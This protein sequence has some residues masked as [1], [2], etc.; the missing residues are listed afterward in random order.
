[1]AAPGVELIVGG[2]RDGVFGP[3]VLVGFGGI[4]A[5]VLDDVAVLLAPVTPA[6]VV[7]RLEGLRGAVL[8]RGVR[9]AA[10][11]DVDALAAL[12]AAVGDL[13]V[14]D[15]SIAEIDLNPVIASPGGVV[16]VD[17][18]VVLAGDPARA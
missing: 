9:G 8:L 1:M 17:A 14:A 7:A 2:R 15:P 6:E 3:A 11:V 5:E 13:L 18:L 10:A 16:A 12:V 4:L